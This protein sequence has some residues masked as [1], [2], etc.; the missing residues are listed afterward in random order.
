MS[1]SLWAHGLYNP[2]NFPGQS[3]EPFPSPGEFSQPRDLNQVS[4]IAGGFFT[5]WASR[6]AHFLFKTGAIFFRCSVFYFKRSP[7]F[8]NTHIHTLWDLH[9]VSFNLQIIWIDSPLAH[10]GTMTISILVTFWEPLAYLTHEFLFL[11]L[12]ITLERHFH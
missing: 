9:I 10:K 7:S 1:N 3:G 4:C 5:S 11:V 8:S 12:I 6:N 2:W